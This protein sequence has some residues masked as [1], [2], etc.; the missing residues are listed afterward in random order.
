MAGAMIGMGYATYFL[1]ML[2]A[3]DDEWDRNT[4]K[5][6]NMQ[7]WVRYARFHL[8][9]E[10]SKAA[11]LGRDIVFQVPWGFGLGSLAS[12]GAQIAGMVHG[13]SNFKDGL[14][15]IVMGSL[16][17]AFLPLPISK[18]PWTEKPGQAAIDSLMPSVLR[19]AIEFYM[20]TDGIGR[21]INSTM[22][23]RMGDDYVGSDRVPEAYKAAADYLFRVSDGYI[24]WT[25]N[26]MYFF[27][28]SYL[29]GISR[30][31]EIGYSWANIEGN[32]KE[33]NPKTDLP[34]FGSFFGAKT[35]VDAREYGSMEQK[36]KEM[37]TRLYTL[38]KQH[39]E[40][41][42]DYEIKHPFDKAIIA[43]Y[44]A[45][46]GDLNEMRNKANKIRWDKFL[47][48]KD[49]TDLLRVIVQEEN[50]I[51]HAMVMDFKAYGMEP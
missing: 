15:N 26:T 32:K 19:P 11:G 25:P 47:S 41:V 42:A 51:K 40:R 33:F 39:P 28:N 35:N 20:N 31:G 34:L 24:S 30:I 48:P 12:M 8:P 6:D 10:V 14:S 43:A 1:S 36:I 22:N 9:N 27:A 49:K 3:P 5:Y 45:R 18:I 29:D 2:G 21:G 44:N 13:Q 4:V 17:D 37:D 50:M 7:Q 38:K 46:Q 23:R 16:A